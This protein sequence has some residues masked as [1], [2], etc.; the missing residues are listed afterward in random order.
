VQKQVPTNT[1]PCTITVGIQIYRPEAVMRFQVFDN[2]KPQTYYLNHLGQIF[3]GYVNGMPFD[4]YREFDLYLPQ[5]PDLA[6][7][8]IFNVN[9]GNLADGAD[10]SFKIVKWEKKEKVNTKPIW[11][12]HDDA[13]FIKF[14]KFFCNNASIL[15][16]TQIIQN[17][18][19][20]SVYRSEGC[21]FI[22]DY[23]D[24]I[25][26]R[27]PQGQL[28]ASGTPARI[29]N[30]TGIIEVSKKDFLNY[31]IP[32]RLIIL[33]HEYSHKYKNPKNGRA[34]DD[35]SAAD[36]AALNMYLSM[37]YSPLEAEQAFLVVFRDANNRENKIR[38]DII[39]GFIKKFMEGN[40]SEYE[41]TVKSVD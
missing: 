17:K 31:T 13:E 2:N 29:G 35:E 7:I 28:S 23:Y 26:D 41:K 19:Y 18:P 5:S 32:M 10:N 38:M 25:I 40:L 30:E 20:P 27:G 8:N 36:L 16:G 1:K 11:I 37:G 12:S 3:N 4:G 39:R 15:S 33:L 21:K 6:N 14:A 34:I 22:I 9:N 24:V